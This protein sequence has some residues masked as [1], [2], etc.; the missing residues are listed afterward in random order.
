M[1]QT[2]KNMALGRFETAAALNTAATHLSLKP[3]N[4]PALPHIIAFLR[5]EAESLTL[6]GIQELNIIKDHADS[7][8]G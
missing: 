7:T 1:N 4:N 2:Y 5:Q 8:K 6:L 3:A